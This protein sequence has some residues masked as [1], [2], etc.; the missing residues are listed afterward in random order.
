MQLSSSAKSFLVVIFIGRRIVHQRHLCSYVTL[1]GQHWSSVV[2]TTAFLTIRDWNALTMDS[3]LF[4][5]LTPSR[6]TS[7]L[8]R[9]F[10]SLAFS[11][12]TFFVGRRRGLYPAAVCFSSLWSRILKG[13]WSWSAVQAVGISVCL[14]VCLSVCHTHDKYQNDWTDKAGCWT[15][16]SL[17]HKPDT[18]TC[19]NKTINFTSIFCNEY[20]L[21]KNKITQHSKSV[22]TVLQHLWLLIAPVFILS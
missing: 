2:N 7:S 3:L 19:N 1:N 4:H 9:H 5:M 15:R 12:L 21:Y 22:P 17:W 13:R 11:L 20:N 14:S 6:T 18:L 8:I 10:N 16:T